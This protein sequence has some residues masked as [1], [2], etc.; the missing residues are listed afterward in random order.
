MLSAVVSDQCCSEPIQKAC[1]SKM[2]E[3]GVQGQ[4]LLIRLLQI[5][6]MGRRGGSSTRLLW[7]PGGLSVGSQVTSHTSKGWKILC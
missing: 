7:P 3:N 4:S 1:V 5:R 2:S 6:I